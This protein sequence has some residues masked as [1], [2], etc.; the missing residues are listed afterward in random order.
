MGLGENVKCAVKRY[1]T[2]L[3]QKGKARVHAAPPAVAAGRKR[4]NPS[5]FAL[6]AACAAR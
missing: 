6:S 2:L 3:L 1:P 4:T 5:G